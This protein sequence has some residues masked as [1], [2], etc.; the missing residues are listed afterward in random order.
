MKN[1]DDLIRGG[2]GRDA[3]DVQC[4]AFCFAS[5]VL[6]AVVLAMAALLGGPL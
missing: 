4:A 1:D 6:L 5:V 3:E 2:Q